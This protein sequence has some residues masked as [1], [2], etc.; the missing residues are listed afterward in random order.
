MEKIWFKKMIVVY[1]HRVEEK[2]IEKIKQLLEENGIWYQIVGDDENTANDYPLLVKH[3]MEIYKQN[4]CDGMILLCGSGTGMNIV[5]NKFK[6]IRAVQP[7]TEAKVYFARR[8]ENAN[9]ISFGTGN[10][11]EFYEIKPLCRRKMARL[12]NVFLK[13]DFAGGRHERRVNE[14]F[15]IEKGN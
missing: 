10:H 2:Y 14:I 6:G 11:D 7:D 1:D 9:V 15:D 13:T 5:A 8:D 4:N 12:I 3:A